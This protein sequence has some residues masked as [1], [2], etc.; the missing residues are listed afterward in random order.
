MCVCACVECPPLWREK[1][2]DGLGLQLPLSYYHTYAPNLSTHVG[3]IYAAC[4]TH[5]HPSIPN[6]QAQI[7]THTRLQVDCAVFAEGFDGVRA[8]CKLV[9]VSTILLSLSNE[10]ACQC[11]SAGRPSVLPHHLSGAPS[12]L[13]DRNSLVLPAHQRCAQRLPPFVHSGFSFFFSFV[14]SRHSIF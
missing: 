1:V 2:A 3:L 4:N 6:S 14:C 12:L 10:P 11:V 9:F 5:T 7:L 8:F 13:A